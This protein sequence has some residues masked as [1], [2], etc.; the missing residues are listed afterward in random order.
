MSY[1]LR[2]VTL[3]V[4]PQVTT[5][6]FAHF[7]TKRFRNVRTRVASTLSRGSRLSPSATSTHGVLAPAGVGPLDHN[8]RRL[9][10]RAR[11]AQGFPWRISSPMA[12]EPAARPAHTSHVV[13]ARP[14]GHRIIASTLIASWTRTL[15]AEKRT[16]SVSPRSKPRRTTH[17]RPGSPVGQARRT[18]RATMIFSHFAESW[19]TAR[20]TQPGISGTE[21]RAVERRGE[22]CLSLVGR[23]PPATIRTRSTA[24]FR[25]GLG[26]GRYVVMTSPATSPTP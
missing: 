9:T 13:A 6:R 24:R 12:S 22:E 23:P 8:H 20:L 1:R 25:R 15:E 19:T 5:N 11:L 3:R 21:R 17:G 18:F 26:D 14:N 2:G 7:T 16:P 10:A 4:D